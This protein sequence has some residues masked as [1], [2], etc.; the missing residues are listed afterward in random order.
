MYIIYKHIFIIKIFIIYL[1]LSQI[2]HL[3]LSPFFD[4]KVVEKK[5]ILNLTSKG[6]LDTI[7]SRRKV[8]SYASTVTEDRT[9]CPIPG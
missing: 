6:L 5:G 4:S 3:L 9:K 7:L 2:I 1:L 8:S